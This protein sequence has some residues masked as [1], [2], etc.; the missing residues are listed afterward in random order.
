M[1]PHLKHS[2]RLQRAG[3]EGGD[4]GW[5]GWMAS[6]TQWTWVW[7]NSR[8]S[9]KQGSLL[10]CSPWGC[11]ESDR[12]SDWATKAAETLLSQRPEVVMHPLLESKKQGLFHLNSMGWECKGNWL[13]GKFQS[14][15]ERENWCWDSEH[16]SFNWSSRNKIK[17]KKKAKADWRLFPRRNQ[18][19][20]IIWTGEWSRI[21]LSYIVTESSKA[22]Y[23]GKKK[24]SERFMLFDLEPGSFWE[25][26]WN[27][28]KFGCCINQGYPEI[29]K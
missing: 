12:L 29:W 14:N 18:M 27:G 2:L 24:I 7:A 22:R 5:D 9:E 28:D 17:M 11:K 8:D 1:H 23:R 4:R 16:V 15:S 10:C 6:P 20:L 19:D 26:I 13:K 3:G 21:W 25:P